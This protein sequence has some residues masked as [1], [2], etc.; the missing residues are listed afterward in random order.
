MS[1]IDTEWSSDPTAINFE[2]GENATD[3]RPS[4]A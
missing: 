4:R 3:V 1:Q 2:S